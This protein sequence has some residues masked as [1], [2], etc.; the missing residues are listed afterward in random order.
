MEQDYSDHLSE[1]MID[2]RLQYSTFKQNLRTV[3]DIFQESA[4]NQLT[5]AQMTDIANQIVKRP[6]TIDQDAVELT[7]DTYDHLGIIRTEIKSFSREKVYQAP[8]YHGRGHSRS[9]DDIVEDL[10]ASM[11]EAE[12]QY[13]WMQRREEEETGLEEYM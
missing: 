11:E 5:L 4:T 1:I 3:P 9:W 6:E 7:A 8:N 12:M 10:E 13:A 2:D